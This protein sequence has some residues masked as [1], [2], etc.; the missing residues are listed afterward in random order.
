[1]C[2]LAQLHLCQ[3]VA[4]LGTCFPHQ[5]GGSSHAMPLVCRIFSQPAGKYTKELWEQLKV[6]LLST[7]AFDSVAKRRPSELLDTTSLVMHKLA[8]LHHRMTVR[9]VPGGRSHAPSRPRTPCCLQSRLP[10]PRARRAWMGRGC[11]AS[12]C[13]ASG[14]QTAP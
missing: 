10:G 7:K 8:P 13:T 4:P 2:Q 5:P 14:M 3:N 6:S 12:S 11:R 1:M 9:R